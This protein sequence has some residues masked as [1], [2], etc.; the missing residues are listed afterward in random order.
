MF[1]M[2]ISD[3]KDWLG[4]TEHPVLALLLLPKDPRRRLMTKTS[5]C[6]R[7]RLNYAECKK[8]WQ[9]CKSKSSSNPNPA[10]LVSPTESLLFKRESFVQ[11]QFTFY[12]RAKLL[13]VIFLHLNKFAFLSPKEPDKKFWWESALRSFLNSW[14]PVTVP[15]F[16]RRHFDAIYWKSK[17]F[18]PH[19]QKIK[20][21]NHQVITAE[22]TQALY[23]F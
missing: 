2:K 19:F 22:F 20:G 21:R 18:Q 16:L 9:Q 10:L 12:C 13:F 8:W 11:K 5:N 1:T 4:P 14:A 6:K 23:N 7:K 3:R 17:S 15:R